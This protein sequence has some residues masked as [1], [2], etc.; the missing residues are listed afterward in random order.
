MNLRLP[1]LGICLLFFAAA[2]DFVWS[3]VPKNDPDQLPIP[4]RVLPLTPREVLTLLPPTPPNWKITTSQATNQISSWLIT[5]AQRQLEALPIDNRAPSGT[6]NQPLPPMHT[7]FMLI[8]TGYD[9]SPA[10][11]FVDFK[12]SRQATVEKTSLRASQ[13]FG[14]DPR[15][16]QSHCKCSSMVV[17]FS[18]SRPK[19]NQRM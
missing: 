19:I 11:A 8:D 2:A 16:H 6:G 5:I 1:G 10:G 9:P 4:P 13:Q 18:V 17:L 14:H 7:T 12:V 15:S 3:Q